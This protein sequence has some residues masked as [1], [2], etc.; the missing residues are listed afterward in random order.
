MLRRPLASGVQSKNS[1]DGYDCAAPLGTQGGGVLITKVLKVETASFCRVFSLIM[2]QESVLTGLLFLL[3]IAVNSKTMLVGAVIGAV[4]AG[5]GSRLWRCGA[6]GAAWEGG[7]FNG[8][9]IGI[10]VLYYFPLAMSSMVL[11]LV[12][13]VLSS[14]VYYRMLRYHWLSPF[15]APFVVSMWVIL[16]V[17]EA[18][19][20]TTHLGSATSTVDGL[21]MVMVV[22]RSIGQV[23]LQ[24]NGLSGVLFVAGL[25]ICSRRAA[26]WAIIGAGLG[27]TLAQV[28]DYPVDLILAGVF[29][30]NAAL[31][32]IALSSR[33]PG[34]VIE[35]LFGIILTVLITQGFQLTPVPPLT[36]PFVLAAWL[37]TMGDWLRK[38]SIGTCIDPAQ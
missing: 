12:G 38:K 17:A 16:V 30:F 33:F 15:T 19:G 34:R 29:G 13:G 18:L 25:W 6:Q 35:P 14:M 9:L 3:G 1:S 32:G 28:F 4:S 11:I 2:L 7:S 21:G 26:T 20:L 10:A 24:E 37:V 31:V 36:A 8:A 23:M 22:L 27:S 5:V